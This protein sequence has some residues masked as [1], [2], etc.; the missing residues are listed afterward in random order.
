M[1]DKKKG[2]REIEVPE[3]AHLLLGVGGVESPVSS[4][5]VV[6]PAAAATPATPDGDELEKPV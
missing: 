2:E 1:Q 4:L 5:Q 3:W 6:A